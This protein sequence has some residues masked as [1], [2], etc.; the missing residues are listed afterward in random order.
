MAENIIDIMA[1]AIIMADV[2][3]P[4]SAADA[5]NPTSDDAFEKSRAAATQ[6]SASPPPSYENAIK[7]A[8]N[9]ESIENAVNAANSPIIPYRSTQP[10]QPPSSQQ[11]TVSK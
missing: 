1:A 3:D 9:K 6:S 10:P 8:T 5:A 7:S 4:S 2:P 11:L